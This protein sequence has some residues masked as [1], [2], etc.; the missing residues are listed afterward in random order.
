[1]DSSSVL[2]V[3]GTVMYWLAELLLL[4]GT[5][6]LAY[7]YRKSSTYVML[8]GA[9]LSFFFSFTGVFINEAFAREGSE[10]LLT[11]YAMLSIL[12]GVSHGVFAVGLI[13]FALSKK[14]GTDSK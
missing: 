14:K 8:L 13:W 5:C 3:V 9:V 2:P 6:L 12:S 11:S 4:G 7:N 1:M 10:A